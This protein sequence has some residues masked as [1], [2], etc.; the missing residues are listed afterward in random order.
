MLFNAVGEVAREQKEQK[1]CLVT[2]SPF[3]LSFQTE[4]GNKQTNK[5]TQTPKS[6]G[7]SFFFSKE[8][9]ALTL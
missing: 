4:N 2:T 8:T 3:Y 5:K 1:G 9:S 7:N 6:S